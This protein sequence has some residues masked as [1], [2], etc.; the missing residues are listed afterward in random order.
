MVLTQGKDKSDRIPI[1]EMLG[2]SPVS[3][4]RTEKEEEKH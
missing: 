3:N 4:I 1:K 2:K